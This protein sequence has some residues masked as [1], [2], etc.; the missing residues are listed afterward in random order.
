MLP[1]FSPFAELML[2]FGLMGGYFQQILIYYLLFLLLDIIAAGIALS[3]EKEKLTQLWI[4]LLQRFLFRQI[5][6]WVLLKS[7]IIALKG[8]L[9]GWGILK[10]TGDVSI[11]QV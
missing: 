1:I 3:F 10:R 8:T 6:Y 2:I 7:I 9:V 4:L 5:M 11:N